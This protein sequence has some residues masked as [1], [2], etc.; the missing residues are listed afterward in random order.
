MQAIITTSLA[1]INQ[2]SF[3]NKLFLFIFYLFG[4]IYKIYP[5]SKAIKFYWFRPKLTSSAVY[6]RIITQTTIGPAQYI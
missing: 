5:K 4:L 3:I 2:G 6:Y 1:S